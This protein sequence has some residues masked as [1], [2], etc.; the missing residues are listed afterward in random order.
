VHSESEYLTIIKQPTTNLNN[1]QPVILRQVIS[2]QT[3]TNTMSL[4]TSQKALWLYRSI[5]RAGT[6]MPTDNRREWVRAKARSE[7]R[8]LQHESDPEVIAFELRL[9]E[10]HL[11]SINVQAK[12]L[13]EIMGGTLIAEQPAPAERDPFS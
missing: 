4:A 7:F 9:G 2:H 13:N 6:K 1:N 12:H 8:R 11:E 10:V 3:T 5:L